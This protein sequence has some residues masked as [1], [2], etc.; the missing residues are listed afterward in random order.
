MACFYSW[1]RDRI[2]E[3]VSTNLGGLGTRARSRPG[4][5]E[6]LWPDPQFQPEPKKS[7]T[8]TDQEFAVV[9]ETDSR[10]VQQ[11]DFGLL[12]A[13]VAYPVRDTSLQFLDTLIKQDMP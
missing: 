3:L 9:P 6:V 13:I 12:D 10:N 11:Q 8:V 4:V 2:M 1:H 5:V 7:V